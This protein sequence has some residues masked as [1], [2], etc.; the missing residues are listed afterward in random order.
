MVRSGNKRSHVDTSNKDKRQRLSV[1]EEEEEIDEI[2]PYVKE[3]EYLDH[4]DEYEPLLREIVAKYLQIKDYYVNKHDNIALFQGEEENGDP[5][6]Y[7]KLFYAQGKQY[8]R[9]L[10][11]M[12]NRL[13]ANLQYCLYFEEKYI[14]I[15]EKRV[16]Q[17]EF[18][19]FAD[20]EDVIRKWIHTRSL[21]VEKEEL[22]HSEDK[23]SDREVVERANRLNALIEQSI[24]TLPD[25][26]IT[27]SDLLYL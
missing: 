6:Q 22:F 10:Q 5:D 1:K 7:D 14:E 18:P 9:E 27:G 8:E 23:L 12:F 4:F 2:F 21:I 26:V 20:N 16:F 19:A 11:D 13:P 3:L 25:D 15:D 24:L 17:Q